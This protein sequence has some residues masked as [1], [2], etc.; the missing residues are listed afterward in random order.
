MRVEV[1]LKELRVSPVEDPLVVLPAEVPPV[2][3][4]Q[5]AVPAEKLLVRPMLSLF[6]PQVEELVEVPML[7]EPVRVLPLE[8]LPA[9][10]PV[11]A[12]PVEGEPRVE[13]VPRVEV[14]RVEVLRVEVPLVEVL[15]VEF[16]EPPLEDPPV[17]LLKLPLLNIA[18]SVRILVKFDVIAKADF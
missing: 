10:E 11:K 5:L 3:L 13:G 7:P 12:L 6:E 8:E 18:I 17:P 15:L 4:L 9:E 1:P 14:P 16:E 2:K